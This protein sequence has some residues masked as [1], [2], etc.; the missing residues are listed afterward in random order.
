MIHDLSSAESIAAQA[1]SLVAFWSVYGRAPGRDLATDD[2]LV[3][4]TTRVPNPLL[5][6]IFSSRLTPSN[7]DATIQATRDYYTAQGLPMLWWVGPTTQPD[8]LADRLVRAGFTRADELPMM[9]IDLQSMKVEPTP[10]NVTVKQVE[11]EE[12]LRVWSRILRD[13]FSLAGTGQNSFEELEIS[14]G[15]DSDGRRYR[16]IA[17]LYDQAVATSALFAEAGVAGIYNVATLPDARQQGIGG[18]IT[19]APLLHAR[20]MGYR[21]GTLQATAMGQPIYRRLGF[22][23]IAPFTLYA[24]SGEQT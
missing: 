22:E 18:A 8:D 11:S 14:L 17:Y 10:P 20:A 7:A 16:F 15:L 24:W 23:H 21:V 3:R 4:L 1:A 19:L 9:A 5:N 13:T 6:G 12:E 2:G